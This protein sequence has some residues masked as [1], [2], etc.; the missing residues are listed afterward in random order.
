MKRNRAMERI[1]LIREYAVKYFKRLEV[2]ILPVIKFLFGLYLFSLINGIGYVHEAVE[3]FS[4]A[5]SPLLM[6]AFFALLFTVMPMSLSWLMIIL[7]LTVQFSA[8]LEVALALFLLLMF[9]FIFYARMAP[10]ESIFILFAIIAFR[11]NVPFLLPLIAGLYFPVSTIIPISIGV[12]LNSQIPTLWRLMEP[13]GVASIIA[14]LGELEFA[15]MVTELPAAFSEVYTA[16][17]SGVSVSGGWLFTA[18]IF[19]MVTVLVHFV[20]RQKFNYAKEIAI[21][22][23]AGMLIFGFVA[24]TIF[25]S[26]EIS[27]PVVVVGTIVASVVALFVRFFDSI[28]DYNRAETV[29][30]EDDENFYH[31][32]IVPKVIAGQFG[33]DTEENIEESTEEEYDDE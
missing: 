25:A 32:K 9:V 27:L 31:V 20:S 16:L 8:N 7:S 30:F 17:M 13:G 3:P 26:Q 4:D 33:K 12:F 10:R 23:G 14:D 24:T 29:Q 28:L 19:S 18:V 2:F 15:D 5:F 6:N 1:L 21:G 11:F 22:L